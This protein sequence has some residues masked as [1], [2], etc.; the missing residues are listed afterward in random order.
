MRIQVAPEGYR[1]K[2][3]AQNWEDGNDTPVLRKVSYR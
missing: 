2:V 1:K 3:S